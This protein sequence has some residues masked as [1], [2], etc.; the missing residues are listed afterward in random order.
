M[1]ENNFHKRTCS[2]SSYLLF[3]MLPIY[4]MVNMSF[5]TNEEILA[6]SRSSPHFT[7]A[8]YKV[9]FTDESWY[10]G[11]HQQPDLRGINT[12]ISLTVVAVAYAFSLFVLG[13]KHVFFYCCRTA[14][15]AAAG[16]LLPFFSSTPPWA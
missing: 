11:L 14:Y 6:P 10:S 3:A 8:N 5:K 7:W 9:I 1:H 13:D 15:D 16:V 12:V 2:C 4:W